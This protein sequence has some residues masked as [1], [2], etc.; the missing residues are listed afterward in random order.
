MNA[1]PLVLASAS[2]RRSE[3]LARLGVPFVVEPAGVDER[4][5]AGPFRAERHAR[6]LARTKA[7]AVAAQFGNAT[8]LAAD[9]IVVLRGR[10][11]EKPVD[12]ADAVR[13]LKELRGRWHRVIT[14]V[15]LLNGPRVR[16]RHVGTRVLMRDYDDAE[17]AAYVATGDPFDKAGS[18]A[19]QATRFRPVQAIAGCHCNVVGLPLL[20]TARLLRGAGIALRTAG[21]I[22][23]PGPCHRCPL[24]T[25]E[26]EWMR[27]A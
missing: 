27:P 25:T 17:I 11:L 9:T 24:M 6:R 19:I 8:V 13:M 14:G 26:D 23:W 15:A 20:T 18:Y 12:A 10:L 4:P 2:P 7:T 5:A 16:V 21:P 3:L 1:A 22:D